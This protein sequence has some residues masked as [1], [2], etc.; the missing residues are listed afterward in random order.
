[1]AWLRANRLF[2]TVQ[3]TPMLLSAPPLEHTPPR[4]VLWTT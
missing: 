1:M 2:S 3:D 4:K